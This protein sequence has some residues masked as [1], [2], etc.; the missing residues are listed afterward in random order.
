V[1]AP[2]MIGLALV[3]K[4]FVAVV[5]GAHWSSAAPLITILAPVAIA[6]A[7]TASASTA[8]LGIGRSTMVFRVSLAT[9]VLV[10]G[11]FILGLHWG[12]VGVA[13]S[14]T[15]VSF[16][17]AGVMLWG[18]ARALGLGAL[19]L[20]SSLRGP[21]EATGAMAAA[22]V[23]AR[24]A[25]A[26]SSTSDAVELVVLVL[27]GVAVYAPL[28]FLRVAP[29]RAELGRLRRRRSKVGS[30]DARALAAAD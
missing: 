25:I 17:S 12:V 11:G 27:V 8:L 24:W 6:Q 16:P 20:L 2:A 28:C 30:G 4:E 5:F 14:L 15:I 1:M 3:S 9:T 13:A 19:E 10:L 7:L 26:G 29:M 23:T 21:L 22:L 18:A